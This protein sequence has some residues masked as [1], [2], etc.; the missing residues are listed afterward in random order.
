MSKR[1]LFAALITGFSGMVIQLLL[2]RELLVVFH[3]NELAIG[4]V[5]ANWLV[6][7]ALGAFF[8]G[9][10]IEQA[11]KRIRWFVAVSLLFVLSAPVALYLARIVRDI[12]GVMPGVGMGVLPIFYSSFLV[13]F[14]PSL[15]HGALFV[16]TC[17]LCAQFKDQESDAHK[18]ASSIGR[19]YVLETIGHIVGAVAF[20]F[21]LINFFHSFAIVFAMCVLVLTASVALATLQDNGGKQKAIA[22]LTAVLVVFV[23]LL[24]S[25][26]D[27]RLHYHALARQ[28]PGQKVV[29]YQH[30]PY[31]NVA[32]I[33]REGEYTFLTDGIPAL[34]TPTPDI[35][36]VE[37]F[38]HF[39]MLAHPQPESVAILSGGAG[40]VISEVLEHPTIKRVDYAEINPL[41]IDLVREFPTPLTEAELGSALVHTLHVD[42]RRFLKL[43]PRQ[44]DLIFVGVSDPTNLQVNRLFTAE[45]ALLARERLKEGGV[46]VVSLPGSLTYLC[47]EL[48]NLNG[49][50]IN[51]LESVFPYL[52]IIPGDNNIILASMTKDVTA[53]DSAQLY[54]RLQ[55][56]QLDLQLISQAHL[57]LRLAPRWVDWFLESMEGATEEINH[58]FRP[59]GFFYSLAYWNAM[60]SPYLRDFFVWL[61]GLR[62]SFFALVILAGTAIFF[63]LKQGTARLRRMSIPYSIA[64]T[65]FA[66]MVFDL[67]LI[68]A[69]QALFGF[70]LHWLGLLVAAFMFGVGG[71][72]L[73]MTTLLPRIKDD[74]ALFIKLEMAVGIFALLLPLVI[75]VTA[76]HLGNVT[77]FVLAQL[78]FLLLSLIAGA[79]VGLKFPLAN[80]IYL[81]RSPDLSRTAGLLYSAD[82]MGGWV[83]G[84][85]AAVLLLPVLGLVGTSLVVVMIKASSLSMLMTSARLG[86]T[87][88]EIELP[89][90]SS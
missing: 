29:H 21:F 82:L 55:E 63:A 64:T 3:G 79:L 47:H 70:A 75:L 78:L 5:L 81:A 23:Y 52:R 58:D 15:L 40:G 46:L 90:A 37:E 12:V 87:G 33:E 18:G 85:I 89:A 24:A 44:Y 54:D 83:G 35:V 36:R 31:G 57:E 80:K 22:L 69:F 34:T 84:I 88:G 13:L 10:R 86:L 49:V 30:S 2:L 56:R 20:V 42:G 65:G 51:T 16:F 60:F 61:E 11:K 43:T 62:L 59:K 1:L 25:D 32:V 19:V 38:V 4:I 41:L 68:F 45:F 76:P 73:A 74:R 50:I 71:G 8:I 14:L 66:G 77:V 39:P 17:K 67:L 72:A 7:E 28:W 27:E 53:F 6:V 48:R 9:K 26:G